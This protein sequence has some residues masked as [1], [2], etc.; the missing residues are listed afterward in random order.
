MSTTE[1][2]LVHPLC[3][4]LVQA[5]AH[6]AALGLSPGSSGNLSVRI[7]D[8]IVMSPTGADLA[9]LEA[10]KL[11]RLTLAGEFLDGPKASKEFPLHQAMYA[12]DPS[13]VSVV[14]L[15]S[16]HAAALS[17]TEP[18]AA[19]SALPPITPYLVMRVGQVPL[20]PYAAP[21][22][23]SQGEHIDGLDLDFR[24]ILLQNHGP[25]TAGTSVQQAVDAIIE[26]EEAAKLV[27]LL[28]DRPTRLL[29]DPEIREL[30]RTYGTSWATAV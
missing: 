27:L 20:I 21:G 7:G 26:I 15:H 22:N 25:L 23:V 29:T 18:W 9:S 17:C 10:D 8:T 12:R 24:A 1:L 3:I 16:P 5:G 19:H 2:D 28:Q 14:H 30:T 4:E 13:A 6:L 11:S